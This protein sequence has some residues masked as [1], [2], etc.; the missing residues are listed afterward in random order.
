MVEQVWHD[1]ST[2]SQEGMLYGE[3]EVE[4][5]LKGRER[6]RLQNPSK[7]GYII[8]HDYDGSQIIL[9]GYD[10]LFLHDGEEIAYEAED[11]EEMHGNLKGWFEEEEENS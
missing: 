2:E 6:Y 10:L 5:T 8:D 9:S 11:F 4:E 7:S 1:L 3:L